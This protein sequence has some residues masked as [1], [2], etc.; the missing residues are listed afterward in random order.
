MARKRLQDEDDLPGIRARID[1]VLRQRG[2]SQA[3]LATLLGTNEVQMSRLMSG[4]TKLTIPWLRRIARALE[5]PVVDLLEDD[6]V[7]LRVT[8]D[9]H[10]L[11]GKLRDDPDFDARAMLG[12]LSALKGVISRY[13][14]RQITRQRLEGDPLLAARLADAWGEMTDQQRNQALEL[15]YAAIRLHDVSAE[16]A[17]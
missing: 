7:P 6:D 14:A 11:L 16:A 13:A 5:V 2:I 12:I 9:D 15:I 3:R 17:A 4:Y 8:A 1:Y 10:E